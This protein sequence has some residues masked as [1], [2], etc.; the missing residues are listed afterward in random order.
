MS[1]QGGESCTPKV[2]KHLLTIAASE[3]VSLRSWHPIVSYLW[4]SQSML[5]RLGLW[6][7]TRCSASLGQLNWACRFTD[8]VSGLHDPTTHRTRAPGVASPQDPILRWRGAAAT[9]RIKPKCSIESNRIKTS[10]FVHTVLRLQVL[11]Q[12]ASLRVRTHFRH[13]HGSIS[14]AGTGGGWSPA[15][16]T[17]VWATALA[18]RKRPVLPCGCGRCLPIPTT[19]QKEKN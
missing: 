3:M 11:A 18:R 12:I 1:R 2:Q 4:A 13:C 5:L 7:H 19:T 15:P 16:S 17:A 10:T 6:G 9:Q 14:A 8:M